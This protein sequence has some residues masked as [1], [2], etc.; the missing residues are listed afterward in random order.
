MKTS[1]KLTTMIKASVMRVQTALVVALILAS[2]S[3]A[4]A[5]AV[6]SAGKDEENAAA[7][8]LS[9]IFMSLTPLAV[10]GTLVYVLYRRIQKLEAETEAARTVPTE[11]S[12]PSR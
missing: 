5:C 7:F 12:A 10:I 11:S 1:M 8:L 4:E 9:T 3:F 2:P 6:C